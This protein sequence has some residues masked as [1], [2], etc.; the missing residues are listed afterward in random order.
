MFN[1]SEYG[2]WLLI[3]GFLIL[4]ILC[5][6]VLVNGFRRIS[7]AR[8]PIPQPRYDPVL[9]P[10][11][12]LPRTSVAIARIN[13]LA[14]QPQIL[15]AQ[16][17]YLR[18]LAFDELRDVALLGLMNRGYLVDLAQVPTLHS[19]DDSGVHA[20]D[21][22]LFVDAHQNG[23]SSSRKGRIS[24]PTGKPASG[25]TSPIL[26]GCLTT[27]VGIPV[28][29]SLYTHERTYSRMGLGEL[30]SACEQS[31]QQGVLIYLGIERSRASISPLIVLID[32]PELLDILL[33][34]T[35]QTLVN[36][37]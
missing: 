24:H 29:L 34:F 26:S 20:F 18:R 5:L 10:A 6:V 12:V 15:S 13:E 23:Q 7:L 19:P 9:L 16:L 14:D 17:N 33:D 8:R 2:R 28:L 22:D 11:D 21:P 35:E 32:G 30:V 31:A 4:M 37:R 1:S 36:L 3:A 25:L 27:P